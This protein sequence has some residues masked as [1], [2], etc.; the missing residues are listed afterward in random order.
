MAMANTDDA[1][2]DTDGLIEDEPAVE[3]TNNSVNVKI[4]TVLNDAA[5]GDLSPGDICDQAEISRNA[6]YENHELLL[7][8]GVIEQTRKVGNAPMYALNTDSELAQ[9][10]IHF[11]DAA[12]DT[13][14]SNEGADS[15]E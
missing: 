1:T 12:I 11:R 15:D 9:A 13:A 8:H 14:P 3:A 7:A 10:F 6:W 2:T 4:L 5:P